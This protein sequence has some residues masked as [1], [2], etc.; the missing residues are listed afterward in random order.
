MSGVVRLHPIHLYGL[1]RNSF[2]STQFIA[3]CLRGSKN[4]ENNLVSK[5]HLDMLGL[6]FGVFRK[7]ARNWVNLLGLMGR[8][9]IKFDCH[10]SRPSIEVAR[11][12]MNHRT[13]HME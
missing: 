6:K 1:D 11:R 5:S 9:E 8:I 3:C 2:I 4:I 7:R 12:E 10:F 13:A